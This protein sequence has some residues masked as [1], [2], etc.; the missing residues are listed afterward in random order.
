LGFGEEHI[1]KGDGFQAADPVAFSFFTA[2][3]AFTNAGIGLRPSFL[4]VAPF[5]LVVVNVIV[6]AGNTFFPI[7]LRWTIIA[8]NKYA[9]DD[10][11]RKI[12]FRCVAN[13]SGPCS[14]LVFSLIL[15]ASCLS[16]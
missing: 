1:N 3:M 7:L 8:L 10:S 12:Y 14:S 11:N 5:L 2:I 16:G 6:L 13:E 15:F 4:G 9:E